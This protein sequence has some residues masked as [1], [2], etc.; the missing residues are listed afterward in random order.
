MVFDWVLNQ[1]K[2][3]CYKKLWK[4][5]EESELA[6]WDETKV[7][8]CQQLAN[9][10]E[11]YKKS[12]C[13]YFLEGLKYLKVRGLKLM[14]THNPEVYDHCNKKKLFAYGRNY[15]FMQA[16]TQIKLSRNKLKIHLKAKNFH[17]F[18]N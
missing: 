8:N 18:K 14:L 10:G 2:R 13:T 5:L 1:K 17:I 16:C 15:S 3:K 7:Q 9:P 12:H 6:I 4:Q 11:R